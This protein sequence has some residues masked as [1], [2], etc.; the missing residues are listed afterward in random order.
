MICEQL[1]LWVSFLFEKVKFSLEAA[2][3][4][5]HNA[6]QGICDASAVSSRHARS[7][8]ED[9]FFHPSVMSISYYS[10]EHMFAVYSPFFLPLSLH[11]ILAVVREIKRY[12]QESRKYAAW[13]ALRKQHSD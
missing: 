9:A 7:L 3:L 6:S 8:A 11:V 2:K 4:A 10:F 5:Q 12:K 1:H 13:E